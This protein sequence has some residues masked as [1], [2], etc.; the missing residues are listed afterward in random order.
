[1]RYGAAGTGSGGASTLVHDLALSAAADVAR[2]DAQRAVLVT[3][4][5]SLVAA[6]GHD[7]DVADCA[8]AAC[9]LTEVAD[10]RVC[11]A[12]HALALLEDTPPAPAAFAVS[13]AD[14]RRALLEASES[15]GA[16]RRTAHP[17]GACWFR[18]GGGDGC[19]TLLRL[20]HRLG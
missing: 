13:W 18:A 17:H 9:Q 14:F 2:L 1:V 6:A 16:C 4:A 5:R 7:P 3:A 8:S 15:I 19:A 11:A 10:P 12:V 20:A